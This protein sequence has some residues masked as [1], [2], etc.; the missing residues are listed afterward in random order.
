MFVWRAGISEWIVLLEAC[1]DNVPRSSTRG[2]DASTAL[3][4]TRALRICTDIAKVTTIVSIYQASENI[5]NLFDKVAVINEGRMSYFGPADK[6]RQY[7]IDMGYQPANRQ[8]TA[9]FLVGVTDAPS[10]IP[11]SGFESRVP[12]TPAEFANY[13]S[14]SSLGRA[15]AEE[16]KNQL[17][18]TIFKDQISMYKSSA[19]ADHAKHIP[20][21]SPYT[22]SLAMQARILMRRRVQIIRGDITT[23]GWYI[24]LS[25]PFLW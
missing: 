20:P 3:E 15:N 8:T 12:R 24:L 19:R 25:C 9:D 13:F 4:F 21:G 7:F 14:K 17:Y 10:R 16:V 18:D 22:V 2:L 6:A 11:R 1:V 23:Q 5:Y